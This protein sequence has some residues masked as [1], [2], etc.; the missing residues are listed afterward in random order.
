VGYERA[1]PT[2]GTTAATTEV[3]TPTTSTGA[4][5][6]C[7]VPA[8]STITASACNTARAVTAGHR[9]SGTSGRLGTTLARGAVAV[10]QDSVNTVRACRRAALAARLVTTTAAATGNELTIA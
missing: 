8:N 7:I 5:A 3:A 1:R 10:S 4:I 6:R 2:T 9:T